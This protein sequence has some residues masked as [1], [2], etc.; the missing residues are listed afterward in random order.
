MVLSSCIRCSC[1]FNIVRFITAQVPSSIV[2]VNC[3]I[4]AQNYS[5]T[6]RSMVCNLGQVLQAHFDEVRIFGVNRV[7]PQVVLFILPEPFKR[8]LDK[9]IG[10][11]L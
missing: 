2:H 8:I 6:T 7:A 1:V 11:M 5:R 10:T 9:A 4:Q 3:E